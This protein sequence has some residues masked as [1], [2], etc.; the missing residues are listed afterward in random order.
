L[1]AVLACI[2]AGCADDDDDVAV[3]DPTVE[4]TTPT[5]DESEATPT[6]AEPTP[7]DTTPEPTPT[8]TV[9]DETP[10][11]GTEASPTS[12]EATPE[13]T[14]I[15]DEAGIEIDV[16][17]VDGEPAVTAT[18]PLPITDIEEIDD[19]VNTIDFCEGAGG[20]AS[21]SFTAPC[22][23]GDRDVV[24]VAVGGALPDIATL[25]LCENES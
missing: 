23:S 5:P 20:L 11:P 8:P 12:E 15:D 7:E 4:D 10:T 6:V 18:T 14:T 2:A 16:S 13:P 25:D 24:V 9:E 22:P 19:I 17:C 3:T 1:V 21:V